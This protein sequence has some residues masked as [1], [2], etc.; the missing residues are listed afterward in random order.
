M[1]EWWR[2]DLDQGQ[3]RCPDRTLHCSALSL[4]TVP[5]FGTSAKDGAPRTRRTGRRIKMRLSLGRMGAAITI[6]FVATTCLA[7]TARKTSSL[8]SL[9]EKVAQ[10]EHMNVRVS[11]VYSVG[12]EN[13]TLDDPECPVAPYQSTW[14]EFDLQMKR[15]DKKLRKLLEH[16]QRVY[17]VSEGEFYGPPLPDPKMPESLQKTFRA[18]WGHLGCCRTKLVV[19]VIWDVKAVPTDQP[20]GASSIHGAGRP[21]GTHATAVNDTLLTAA[22]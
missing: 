17:L 18:H 21:E 6:C 10:G 8:C 4:A 13:S 15:N 22:P 2:V 14:V 7:Q 16:S 11:G 19:H 12:P 1:I 9:Q 5:P 3:S 20:S